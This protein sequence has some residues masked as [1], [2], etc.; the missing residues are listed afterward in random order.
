MGRRGVTSAQESKEMSNRAAENNNFPRAVEF[1]KKVATSA[2][3]KR[4][5]KSPPKVIHQPT[6]RY[7]TVKRSLLL[8]GVFWLFAHKMPSH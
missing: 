5:I 3:G 4:I 8:V 1:T 7:I 2:Q 6:Q